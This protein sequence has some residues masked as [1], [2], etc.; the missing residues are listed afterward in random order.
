M[1]VR[2]RPKGIKFSFHR[3][4]IRRAHQRFNLLSTKLTTMSNYNVAP[5]DKL[6]L[7]CRSK[8]DFTSK[9]IRFL[10]AIC[11]PP[12]V[13]NDVKDTMSKVAK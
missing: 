4:P 8:F 9:E 5:N 6:T 12:D 2:Q 1:L 7:S 10:R 11:F 13:V 3:A